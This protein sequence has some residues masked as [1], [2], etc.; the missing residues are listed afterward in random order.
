MKDCVKDIKLWNTRNFLL[1][2]S[3]ETKVLLLGIKSTCN[4]AAYVIL[5]LNVFFCVS[6][7]NM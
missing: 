3:Y 5:D 1:Q 4:K 2:K 6:A 7:S